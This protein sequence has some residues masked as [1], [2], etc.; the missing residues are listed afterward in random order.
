MR[1]KFPFFIFLSSLLA[2]FQGFAQNSYKTDVLI[3]GGGASGTTA[4]IQA[5]KMGVKVL[6]IE[7][8]E[9]LGGM[10]TSAGVSA[11]DGNH[12]MPSGLWGEFRQHLYDY[13]GGPKAVETGWVSN[14]LFEPSF[15]NK[16]LQKMAQLPNLTVWYKSKLNN[17]SRSSKL[18]TAT[19]NV[20][21]KSQLVEAKIL[22]DA[23]ETKLFNEKSIF[24]TLSNASDFFENGDL[25]YSPNK[26]KFDGLRLK[27]Y[28]WE[29]RPLDVQNVKSSFFENEEIFPKG[30]VTFDNALLMTNIEHEWKSEMDK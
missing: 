27:A 12:N 9:W 30:S 16:T 23:T 24:E 13:Y 7:E 5:A 29:V 25:G 14:T 19:I 4:A 1:I 22:I 26:D 21:G 28:N 6:V 2:F 17:V 15:G 3:I 20:K 10:L 11:I 8:T 18:W